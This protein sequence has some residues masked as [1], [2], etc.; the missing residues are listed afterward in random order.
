[1]L[2]DFLVN[3]YWGPVRSQSIESCHIGPCA[4]VDSNWGYH[5][6]SDD[7]GV[8][9]ANA[10]DPSIAKLSYFITRLVLLRL[11]SNINNIIVLVNIFTSNESLIILVWYCKRVI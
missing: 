3:N 11:I 5:R 10:A 7:R 1:M 4:E 8:A 2:A 6:H 9:A